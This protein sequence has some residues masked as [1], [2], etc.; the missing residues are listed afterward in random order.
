[1]ELFNLTD[2]LSE[3]NN[4]V[5]AQPTMAAELRSELAAWRTAVGAQMMEP[6]PDYDPSVQR[7]EKG[8]KKK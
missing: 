4:L 5:S 7:R 6:N 2:D 8:A 3:K 1:L